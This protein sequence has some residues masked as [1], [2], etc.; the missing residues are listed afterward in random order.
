MLA[1]GPLDLFAD[2][3]VKPFQAW[4]GA[5]RTADALRALSAAGLGVIAAQDD[6]VLRDGARLELMDRLKSVAGHL[7]TVDAHTGSPP[8]SVPVMIERQLAFGFTE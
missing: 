5:R 7:V 8:E 3:N 2:A 1:L 6:R 4:R